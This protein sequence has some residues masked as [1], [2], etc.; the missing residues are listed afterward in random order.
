MSRSSETT[1]KVKIETNTLKPAGGTEATQ[2]TEIST[3]AKS[4]QGDQVKE[5]MSSELAVSLKRARPS[6]T[7]NISR[8]QE[9][10]SRRF[11]KSCPKCNEIRRA[12]NHE[13]GKL[14][15]QKS[16][17][18][19]KLEEQIEVLKRDKEQLLNTVTILQGLYKAI[20]A[21]KKELK[22]SNTKLVSKINNL[23]KILN[24]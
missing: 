1:D 8:S 16:Q 21:E 15:K 17:E 5:A 4:R 12:L 13:M 23:K 20:E 7:M 9:I 22:A 6:E 2:T 3:D 11:M 14:R 18:S 19:R 10:S 24:N